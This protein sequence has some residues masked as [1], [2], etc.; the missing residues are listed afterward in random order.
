MV[1]RLVSPLNDRFQFWYAGHLIATSRSPYDQSAWT[2]AAA[3]YGEVAA[4]VARNCP[5]ALAST[6]LWAY[7]PWTAWLFAPFGLL[8]AERG[9]GAIAWLG[10][11]SGAASAILLTRA[12]PLTASSTM[13]VALVTVASAPFVWASFLGQFE[14]LLLIGALLVARALRDGDAVPLAVG[15]VLLSLKPN[16]CV[17]LGPLVA[18]VLVVRRA[19]P[20]LV[21][22]TAVLGALGA[23]G[24]WREPG[25]LTA[26]A[27]AGA[28]TAIV[29][30]TTWSFAARAAPSVAP[31]LALGLVAISIAAA[32]T[33]VRAARPAVRD[34]TLVAAGLGLSLA[35]TPYAHLYDHV[36]LLPAIAVTIG[37]LDGHGARARMMG[38]IAVGFGYVAVTWLA[39]LAG[40]HGD[41]PA[42]AALIPVATLVAL[43]GATRW[44]ASAEPRARA[45]QA[46][47]AGPGHTRSRGPG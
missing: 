36:L 19:W 12:L 27:G 2:G 47:S 45:G 28:K 25:A 6:C 20:S 30:P 31:L 5:D 22:T 34:L 7:P 3:A 15:A 23:V 37:V 24:I 26:L 8:D 4:L 33:A 46:R 1:G 43:A 10:F 11:V 41:E 14:P 40:P 16:L 35:I 9:I 32:W 39:F 29:L 42:A 13:V 44:R 21:A 17:A 38:W 18:G